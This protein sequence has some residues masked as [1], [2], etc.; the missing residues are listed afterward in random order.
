MSGWSVKASPLSGE[1]WEV[2]D[3]D[4]TVVADMIPDEAIARMM[5]AAP[6]LLEVVRSFVELAE[7]DQ[8]TIE[9]SIATEDP[10]ISDAKAAIAKAEGGAK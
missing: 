5:A 6:D 9:G 3:E 8:L 7:G 2:R 10:V 4:G 1:Y